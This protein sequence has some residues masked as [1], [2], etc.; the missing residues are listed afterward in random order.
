MLKHPK[1]SMIKLEQALR[2]K[3]MLL[4]KGLR[5]VR[6]KAWHYANYGQKLP[7]SISL[8]VPPV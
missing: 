7:L 4:G 8:L 2:T 3:T 1:N 6:G 5:L